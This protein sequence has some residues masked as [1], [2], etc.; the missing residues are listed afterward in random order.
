MQ[1]VFAQ[2][3]HSALAP[4]LITLLQLG[5]AVRAQHLNQVLARKEVAQHFPLLHPL[6]VVEV[7][8]DQREPVVRQ[9]GQAAGHLIAT[10]QAEQETL[11]VQHLLKEIMVAM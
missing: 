5:L 6:V 7:N 1:V 4:E 9:A 3:H 2:G 10:R 8:Q 11:Q